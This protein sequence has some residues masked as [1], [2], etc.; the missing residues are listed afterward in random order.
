MW[1]LQTGCVCVLLDTHTHLPYLKLIHSIQLNG[2][3]NKGRSTYLNVTD[4]ATNRTTESYIKG[5][6][7]RWLITAVSVGSNRA[8]WILFW[9]D[10]VT[11]A[12]AGDFRT[13][14]PAAYHL[15]TNLI[16]HQR[17]P[18]ACLILLI[19]NCVCIYCCRLIV[20]Y[21]NCY[22]SGCC[23]LGQYYKF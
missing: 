22:V 5:N 2:I 18:D 16:S 6:N 17:M 20:F 11:Y 10:F 7:V 23:M 1:I 3:E 14:P 12:A 4:V 9:S 19:S 15:H 8:C 13:D 21:I